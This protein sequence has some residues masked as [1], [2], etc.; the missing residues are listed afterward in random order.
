[1]TIVQCP[2]CTIVYC[3]KCNELAKA[4][5]DKTCEQV[6]L[7]K[8]QRLQA[9]SRNR[10]ASAM[11]AAVVR[12]CP[13]CRAPFFKE[14]GCNK[15]TCPGCNTLSCYIC[16]QKIADYDHFCKAPH[17]DHRSCGKCILFTDSKVDDRRARHEV[18]QRGQENARDNQAEAA[19]ISKLLLSPGSKLRRD[20]PPPQDHQPRVPRRPPLA[21]VERIPPPRPRRMALEHVR[22]S[23][24]RRR[25]PIAACALDS[26]RRRQD[27]RGAQDLALYRVDAIL[28]NPN[29]PNGAVIAQ[30]RFGLFSKYCFSVAAV[31]VL[32]LIWLIA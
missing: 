19:E 11:T 2:R 1:M 12:Q 27:E 28:P 30:Q 5:Q 10:V 14:V 20:S 26:P 15:M 17:C 29:P 22:N 21:L 25:R 32:L 31:T 3:C 24:P 8:K 18:A 7:E 23:P 6:K 13:G 9:D 4:H 16:H